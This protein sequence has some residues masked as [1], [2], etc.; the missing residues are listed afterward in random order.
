MFGTSQRFLAA[1]IGFGSLVLSVGASE[2]AAAAPVTPTL[3]PALPCFSPA[4]NSELT[5]EGWTPGGTVH[6]TGTYGSGSPALDE[7]LTADSGGRIHFDSAVPNDA[8]ITRA[9]RVTAEDVTRAG[10]GAPIEQRQATA[11]FRITWW[12]PFY[13]PWNTNGTAIGHPGRIRTLEA[14]GYLSGHLTNMLFAHYIPLAGSGRVKTVRVGRL[15]GQ[16]GGLKV[17]FREFNFRPVPRG[18]YEV[19]FDTSPFSEDDILDS[20]RYARVKIRRRVP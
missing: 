15:H 16:C 7:D 14:S 20:P 1:L 10:A 12:G 5:G 8:A 2:P 3:V 4:T 17:R 9:V 13:R 6:L 18:T 19:S 11:H